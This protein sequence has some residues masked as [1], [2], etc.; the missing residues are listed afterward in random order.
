MVEQLFSSQNSLFLKPGHK[1]DSFY[2][3]LAFLERSLCDHGSHCVDTVGAFQ[4]HLIEGPFD[5]ELIE[6]IQS[7]TFDFS[8][9]ILCGGVAP[10]VG[11]HCGAAR[12]QYTVHF[13]DGLNGLRKVLERRLAK[14][15]IECAILEWHDRG[16]AF[17]KVNVQTCFGGIFT[18]DLDKGFADVEAGNLK[19][20]K[21][22]Q[23][24]LQKY[25][26]PGAISS[27]EPLAGIF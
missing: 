5:K 3:D 1:S 2:V 4:Q 15:E 14:C 7:H 8:L 9:N 6:R 12:L 23:L 27:T 22:G 11:D 18:S 26:G 13:S 17:P 19:I 16:I 20:A 24:G 25:P 21:P 10:H